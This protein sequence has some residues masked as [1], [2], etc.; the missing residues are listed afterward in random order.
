MDP[1]GLLFM[2]LTLLLVAIAIIAPRFDK[3]DK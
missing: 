3:Q 1:V 2:A